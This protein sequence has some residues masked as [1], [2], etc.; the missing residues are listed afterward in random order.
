M[1][2]ER[3]TTADSDLTRLQGT[4]LEGGYEIEE[5]L[6][7]DQHGWRFKVRV[8]GDASAHAVVNISKLDGEAAQQ[9]LELWESIKG[10][11]HPNLSTA[12]AAGRMQWDGVDLK[13]VV[14]R[15]P[16]QVLEEVLRVR[17][18][19]PG[20]AGE[21]LLALSGALQYLHTRGFVHGCLSPEEV[22]ATGDS[23]YLSTECVR[24]AGS[25]SGLRSKRPKY[26]APE[27]SVENLTPEADVWCLGATLFEA[28]TQKECRDGCRE[29]AGRLGQPLGSIAARCLDP[30]PQTRCKLDEIAALYRSEESPVLRLEEN[31]LRET[32]QGWRPPRNIPKEEPEQARRWWI[33]APIAAIALCAVIWFARSKP[34]PRP[35]VAAAVTAAPNVTP[36]KSDNTVPNET[37]SPERSSVPKVQAP[38]AEKGRNR[39]VKPGTATVNGPV[40]RVVLYTYFRTED[41]QKKARAI[42]E[43]HPG[44]KAEVFA[45]QSQH[46]AYLVVAGGPMTRAQATRLRRKVI[47]MGLP[48][49]SYIQ[50]YRQ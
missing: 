38:M 16:E 37:L 33:Y 3:A 47:S 50:N 7:A 48:R 1:N 23:I 5:L 6:R 4:V 27:S 21:V 40:W 26:L 39:P 17:S 49:D 42:N 11:E 41:A 14:L 8:L 19:A 10:F 2:Q 28:L 9:Q 13:Y 15:R 34:R 25:G 36:S 44:V 46:T 43:K 30:D 12:L 45:P 18:L 24:R 22:L 20:E 31:P 29:S 32:P 35:P